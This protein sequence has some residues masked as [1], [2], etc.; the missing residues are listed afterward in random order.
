MKIAIV[1]SSHPYRGGLAAY[2]ERLAKEY[3]DNNHDV[4][5]YTFTLQYPNF[6]FPGETQF[7][8]EQK[9]PN[10]KIVRC[11]NSV[12][13]LNWLSVGNKIR[14]SRPDILVIKFWLPFMGPC[15]GTI[16]RL[17]KRNR[18][19][20]VICIVDNYIPH[21]KRLGDKIFTKYFSKPIDAFIAM[22]KSVLK[23]LEL[24][25][26]DKPNCL[27]PHPLFDNFGSK[28]SKIEACKFLGLR[29]D[30]RY[31]LFFGL[32]RDYKGL[33]ILIKAFSDDRFRN[34][35]IK[36]IIAGEYY[37]NREFYENLIEQN[38]L[39]QDIIQFN[40]FIPDSEVK[41]FFNAADLIVQPYKSATQSGVTQIAF[42]FE[43]PMILTD[44]GGL[45]EL[46]PDGKVGYLTKV[47]IEEIAEAI[48]RFYGDTDIA[49]MV[50]NIKKEKI[51]YSWSVMVN[52]INKLIEKAN[53]I[54]Q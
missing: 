37:G 27:S 36:L 45:S 30:I 48:S 44:V 1:G 13:P 12:N 25:E 47:N 7:S 40:K 53:E 10:L 51:K 9:P 28:V 14:K 6:L 54:H 15:F 2:N 31:M 26:K 16:L 52:A 32:I 21:E 43:K 22:S 29:H 19:T 34:Q 8:S 42:H 46:C 11:I 20:K 39:N 41:Y 3:Q 33:D 23:D 49:K 17:V 50:E 4:I 38:K 35:N 5:V 24:Y 18:H